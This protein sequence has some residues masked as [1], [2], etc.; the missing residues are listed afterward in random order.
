MLERVR[1]MAVRSAVATLQRS[2]TKA[3]ERTVVRD[4]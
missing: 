4:L 3:V 2:M 1:P